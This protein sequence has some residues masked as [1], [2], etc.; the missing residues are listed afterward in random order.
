MR[1]VCDRHCNDVTCVDQAAVAAES[2]DE[3][4][5]GHES[6][7]ESDEDQLDGEKKTKKVQIHTLRPFL[8]KST[9]R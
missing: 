3:S 4:A 2:G 1:Q 5:S 9:T 7:D 6:D 8:R